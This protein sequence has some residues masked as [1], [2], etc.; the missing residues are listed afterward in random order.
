ME[1]SKNSLNNNILYTNDELTIS[2]WQK[3]HKCSDCGVTEINFNRT[4]C[5]HCQGLYASKHHQK[6]NDEE[7]K[8]MWFDLTLTV[9]D[10]A[11]HF[12]VRINAIYIRARV[13][14]LPKRKELRGKQ[15][16]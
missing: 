11:K 2:V 1:K 3:K 5:H 4:R 13:L 8:K 10:L 7:L 9:K 6:I 12:D 14:G 15:K 16:Q